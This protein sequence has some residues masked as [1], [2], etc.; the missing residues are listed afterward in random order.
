[1]KNVVKQW[2]DQSNYD[3]NTAKAMYKTARYLYVAFMCQQAVEKQLKALICNKTDKMPPYVHNLTTLSEQLKL[4]LSDEQLDLLDLLTRYYLNARYPVVKQALAKS[5][6]KKD[7]FD[8]LRKTEAL[9][10]W[11]RKK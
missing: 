10:K 9:I 11:L 7:C 8:L 2:L 5:L 6:N 3:L 4:K 1:M